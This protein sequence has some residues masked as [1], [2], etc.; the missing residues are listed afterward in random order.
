MKLDRNFKMNK[1]TK[2]MLTLMPDQTHYSFLKKAFAEAEQH[3]SS[4]KK[5]MS[6]KHVT[7]DTED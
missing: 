1:M 3:A 5:K 7:T 2:V 4:A 6:V